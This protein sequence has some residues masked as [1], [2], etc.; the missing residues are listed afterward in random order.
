MNELDTYVQ[1]STSSTAGLM[2][3]VLNVCLNVLQG[4]RMMELWAVKEDS[5]TV[6]LFCNFAKIDNYKMS[7]IYLTSSFENIFALLSFLGV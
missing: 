1:L 5:L 4:C 2:R 7:I 3:R 6:N